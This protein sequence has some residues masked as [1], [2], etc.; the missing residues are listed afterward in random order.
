MLSM[1][2]GRMTLIGNDGDPR[3]GAKTMYDAKTSERVRLQIGKEGNG[4]SPPTR[5]G[6]FMH[7]TNDRRRNTDGLERWFW[8]VGEDTYTPSPSIHLHLHL[9][10]S[11]GSIHKKVSLTLPTRTNQITEL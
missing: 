9:F 1:Q 11:S 4:P 2:D 3:G 10:L 8:D 7:P 5:P 6:P